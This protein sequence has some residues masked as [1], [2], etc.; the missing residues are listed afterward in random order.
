MNRKIDI[1]EE[2][3]EWDFPNHTYHVDQHAG[4]MIGYVRKGT[5]QLETFSKPMGFSKS[6]RKFKK[7]GSYDLD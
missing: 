7:L 1:L 2:I 3:T 4:K 6:Y 5:T